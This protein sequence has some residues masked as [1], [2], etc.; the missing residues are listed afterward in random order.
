MG[1][2]QLVPFVEKAHSLARG[3][4]KL[5]LERLPGCGGQLRQGLRGQHLPLPPLGQ[6]EGIAGLRQQPMPGLR[7]S[8]GQSLL[9][10]EPPFR[11]EALRLRR[12]IL[13][14]CK[15][16]PSPQLL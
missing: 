6:H 1:S 13:S 11:R 14:R 8:L 12:P 4:M 5:A 16:R 7:L 9:Q 3:L 15:H 2:R 10:T